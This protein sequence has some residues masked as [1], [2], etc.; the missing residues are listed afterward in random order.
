MPTV[1]QHLAAIR[2]CFDWFV[3]NHVVAFNSASSV[4]GPKYS[5]R[6]G[7]TPVLTAYDNALMESTIG[8]F[9]SELIHARSTSWCSRQEVETATMR[10]VRWFN[11]RR[12]HSS[13]DYVSP[14]DFEMAYTQAQ[15][16]PRLA[17]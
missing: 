4:R 2:K 15:A 3:V 7:K 17:A 1:K 16:M 13:L 10:W 11:C 8:L 5:V 14:V 6:R 12:L 9:K